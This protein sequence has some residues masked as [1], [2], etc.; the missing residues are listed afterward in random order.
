MKHA[1]T[2]GEELEQEKKWRSSIHSRGSHISLDGIPRLMNREH[3]QQSHGSRGDASVGLVKKGNV[4]QQLHNSST[5]PSQHVQG[6]FTG[7]KRMSRE[8][9]L[10]GMSTKSD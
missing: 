3:I 4:Q 7:R 1:A 10:G 5:A 8:E 9:C 6:S 2:T